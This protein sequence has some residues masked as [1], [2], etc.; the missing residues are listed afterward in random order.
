MEY[1]LKIKVND[2]IFLK[3]PDS[4]EL[5]KQIVKNSIDLIC[6]IG[7]E[8]F[9]FKKL[10]LLINSTEASIYRYFEN[11]H[12][13]LLYITNLYWSYMHYIVTYHLKGKDVAEKLNNLVE[14]VTQIP[15]LPIQL[16]FNKE[17]L[18]KIVIQESSKT[19]LIEEVNKVN[20]ENMFQSYKDLCQVISSLIYE[21]N[22]NYKYPHSLASTLL[23]VAHSQQ[24]FAEHLPRLTDVTKV[25]KKDYTK[26]FLLN[27]LFK[28]LD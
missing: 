2:K 17:A 10:S 11:K 14:I 4:T 27:L 9:T 23:E 28:I 21:Y 20:K 24:F 5:G 16:E 15:D 25:G 19:F 13:L 18:N 7:F 26:R 6:K 22:P 3:D 1:S 8:S 12:R